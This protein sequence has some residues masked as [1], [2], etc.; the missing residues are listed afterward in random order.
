MGMSLAAWQDQLDIRGTALTGNMDVAFIN[1][2]LIKI[3]ADRRR[4]PV[5]PTTTAR[6]TCDGQSIYLDVEIDI[7]DAHPGLNIWFEYEI[8]NRGSLPVKLQTATDPNKLLYPGVLKV[9][10]SLSKNVLESGETASGRINLTLQK[11]KENSEI[12]FL[13]RLDFVQWNF[14]GD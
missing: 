10:N 6:I 7:A 12:N 9:E 1:C 2:R 5:L 4:T 14:F 13:L 3:E 11:L 8:E